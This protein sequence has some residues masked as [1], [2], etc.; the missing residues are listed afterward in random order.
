MKKLLVLLFS[1]F[2]LSSPSVYADDIS[3]FEIEG[4]SIGD[5]LLD[6]MTEDEILEE[7]E[8]NKND[9]LY[10]KE[11]NK[12]AQIYFWEVL[13]AYD[14]GISV[15]IKNNPTNQYISNK[16]EKYIILSI[17]GTMNFI[18]DFDGCIQ[19]RDEIVGE[20]SKMFPN[21]QKSEA[22]FKHPADPLGNSIVDA[23]YFEYDSGAEIETS[24]DNFEETFRIKNNWSEGL[25]V[26]ISSAEISS[27]L[28]NH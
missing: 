28:Q 20:L 4:M 22:F 2:F 15:F 9:Y 24:C 3:D 11:T 10:L 12:Y 26:S 21:T 6:Y 14:I 7:I 16:N 25:N 13:P 27:W 19:K 1:L 17:F 18:E 23:L 8:L 5:S